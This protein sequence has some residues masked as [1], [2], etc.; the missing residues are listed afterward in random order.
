MSLRGVWFC[1]ITISDGTR[2]GLRVRWRRTKGQGRG[3][4]PEK[5]VGEPDG[6]DF[7]N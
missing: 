4:Y 7:L 3:T 5:H 6:R 1:G 2:S